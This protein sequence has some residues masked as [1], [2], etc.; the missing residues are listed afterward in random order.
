MLLAITG[1]VPRVTTLSHVVSS[2]APTLKVLH[3][4]QAKAWTLLTSDNSK[5]LVVTMHK[6]PGLDDLNVG[7]E[8]ATIQQ[9]VGSSASVEVLEAPTAAAVL[10]Q[11]TACLFVH[12]ACH[13]SSNA[14]QPSKS[15][16]LLGTGSVERLTVDDL[17]SLNHQLAQVA[18]LSACSTAEI[19][20][21]TLIDE[22]IHLASTFQ[23][24][25][26]L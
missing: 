15:A 19:G 26:S 4:S 21:R 14:E 7:D 17:Q 25:G 24:V 6:T 2:Y 11:V 18:Y 10:K 9:H 22:S 16:L 1:W 3:F 5:V 13:G 20:A 8:I 23:L 12:F